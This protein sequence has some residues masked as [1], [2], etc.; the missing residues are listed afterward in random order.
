[1]LDGRNTA[2]RMVLPSGAATEI[3]SA[4]LTV[5]PGGATT[6]GFVGGGGVEVGGAAMVPVPHT[7]TSGVWAGISEPGGECGIHE[8]RRTC[9][10]TI[11]PTAGGDQERL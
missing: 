5:T 6:G 7:R 8:V 10:V 11:E 3:Y 9:D 4:P 2:A 1:M